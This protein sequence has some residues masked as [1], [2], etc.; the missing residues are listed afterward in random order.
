[1]QHIRRLVDA[2]IQQPSLIAIGVFD[3]VHRGHQALVRRLVSEAHAQD[4]LA[5]ILTFYPHPDIVLGRASGR[6][7]LSTPDQRAEMLKELGVDLTITH[8]FDESVREIRAVDF[9]RQLVKHLRMKALWVGEDFALGYRREGNVPFLTKLGAD[10]D[11]TVNVIDFVH[12]DGNGGRVSSSQVRQ[13]ILDGDM[14][15]TSE[16]LG[17]A[18]F[19]E[20]EVIHGD[21]RGRTIGFPTANLAIWSEQ[22]LP[23]LGVYAGWATISGETHMAVTNVGIRPTFAGDDLRVETHLLDF[24]REI[25]GEQLR[26]TFETFLR[27]E[28]KFDGIDQLKAQLATDIQNGREFLLANPLS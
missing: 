4:H 17:R 12:P 1:M 18:Y 10:Y 14:A 3:G 16:W 5:V 27:P 20:G 28:Q 22:L 7:Y 19:V 9:V 8:P 6:F 24:D 21:K 2:D 26:L 13:F 25:Y 15:S 23:K 11:F